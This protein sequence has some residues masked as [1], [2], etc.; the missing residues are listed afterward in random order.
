[1]Q[2]SELIADQ[3]IEDSGVLENAKKKMTSHSCKSNTELT[4]I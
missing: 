4:E 3:T 2:T 1:M